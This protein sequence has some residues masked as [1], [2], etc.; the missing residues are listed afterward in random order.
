MDVLRLAEIGDEPLQADVRERV[1]EQ[2]LQDLERH[3]RD[4]GSGEGCATLTEGAGVTPSVGATWR[5]TC[6]RV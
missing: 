4:V 6:I 1:V 5:W 3:R 2:Q